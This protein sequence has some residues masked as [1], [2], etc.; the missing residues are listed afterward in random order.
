MEDAVVEFV[1]PS[2]KRQ[3]LED[4]DTAGVTD[5]LDDI[6]DTSPAEA[7]SAKQV[8]PP[9]TF[10]IA[11]APIIATSKTPQL[12]G[13]GLSDP[14]AESSNERSGSRL[15]NSLSPCEYAADALATQGSD[16]IEAGDITNEVSKMETQLDHQDMQRSPPPAMARI[17]SEAT[18]MPGTGEEEEEK[19]QPTAHFAQDG[20]RAQSEISRA[21]LSLTSEVANVAIAQ[22]PQVKPPNAAKLSEQT[23][24]E[25]AE[26]NK[27]NEEA[28]FEMDSSPLES[29]SS[30]SSDEPSSSDE[31]AADYEMLNPEEQASRLMAEDG[32]S[33][34]EGGGKGSKPTG[35]LRTTNEKPNEVVPKPDIVIT[36][37][38]KIEELGRVENTVENFVLIKA[39]TSGE[40]QVLEF[41]S[42]L[43]LEDKTVIGV[44]AETLGRV[45]QP[46]Y[47]VH[48]TSPA[49]ISEA[50]I[51]EDTRIFYVEQHSTYVFTQPLKAFKGSD[52]SNIHD[53]EVGDDE[54]EF[55]DDEAEAEHK[56]RVKQQRQ[57][58]RG[59]READMDKFSRG[60]RGRRRAAARQLGAPHAYSSGLQPT[61]E[62]S[63]SKEVALNYDD[64]DGM[65][66]DGPGDEL[67]TP[68]ARPTNLHEIMGRQEAPTET[69]VNGF[70]SPRG[71]TSR[72]RGRGDRGFDRGR[73]RGRGRGQ[74]NFGRGASDRGSCGSAHT[75]G[76]ANGPAASMQSN[77]FAGPPPPPQQS[78]IISHPQHSS[79]PAWGSR[80]QAGHNHQQ[81]AQQYQGHCPYPPSQALYGA[82][83]GPAQ[84]QQAFQNFP[85]A[86]A[87]QI[88]QHASA[89]PPIPSNIPPGAHINPAFFRQQAQ[90]PPPDSWQQMLQQPPYNKSQ[91]YSG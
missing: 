19:G 48:F 75:D 78:P 30:D 36:A 73:G 58:R 79:Y 72:G 77:G 45:Q 49:A 20:R 39:K 51:S 3:R 9:Q 40:Y 41:G 53:E 12:P 89:H 14:A 81:Y 37:D 84:Q 15:L 32:G 68:L 17:E 29:S 65:S 18:Q 63:P 16:T 10:P 21:G 43:C 64:G 25:V 67:Y 62:H 42:V 90:N 44:V 2:P 82:P 66:P 86:Q 4:P 91:G 8:P 38:M 47:S 71:N 1:V 70:H 6:Y 31:S 85:P 54:L 59:G 57:V 46:Y 76:H 24:E 56:K 80:E 83:Q 28:E 26:A 13:L 5:E 61:Q 55:S 60:P 7:K 87:Y 88:S 34:E 33:D 23:F 52:A 27:T 35:P 22:S 11:N 50:G 74:S 69:H